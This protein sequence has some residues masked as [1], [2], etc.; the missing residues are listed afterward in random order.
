[1]NVLTRR[2]LSFAPGWPESL[3]LPGK[4]GSIRSHHDHSRSG[5]PRS[6][7]PLPNKPIPKKGLKQIMLEPIERY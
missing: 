6:F 4:R 3:R 7:K 5:E 2:S 1:M